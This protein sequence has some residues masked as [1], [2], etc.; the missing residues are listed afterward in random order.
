M[1]YAFATIGAIHSRNKAEQ[2]SVCDPQASC[3]GPGDWGG[4]DL[5]Y[6]IECNAL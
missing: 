1:T 6:L 4:I 3:H 5:V 2:C